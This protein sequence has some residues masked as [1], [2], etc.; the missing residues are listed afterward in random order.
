[1]QGYFNHLSWIYDLNV[2]V[3]I[4]VGVKRDTDEAEFLIKYVTQ[5]DTDNAS[6][7]PWGQNEWQRL[8]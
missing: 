8:S 2:F 7:M 3:L 5:Y 4:H 1:M 6:V